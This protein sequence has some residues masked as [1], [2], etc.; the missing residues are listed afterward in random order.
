MGIDKLILFCLKYRF[1][2]ILVS[3]NSPTGNLTP[4]VTEYLF[5]VLF[6][7]RFGHFL[8]LFCELSSNSTSWNESHSRAACDQRLVSYFS[9]MIVLKYVL[10]CRVRFVVLS[11]TGNAMWTKS[12][13]HPKNAIVNAILFPFG[14]LTGCS[15]CC[16]ASQRQIQ[17]RNQVSR[18]FS[19]YKCLYLSRVIYKYW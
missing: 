9:S 8:F 12:L 14:H 16:S 19:L 17:Y 18:V 5:S 4:N 7:A 3:D 2:R 10:L 15:Q 13:P 6:T 11:T 1:H